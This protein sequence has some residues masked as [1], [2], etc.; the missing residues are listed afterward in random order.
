MVILLLFDFI[1]ELELVNF[2]QILK[3]NF[4]VMLKLTLAVNNS[5]NIFQTYNSYLKPFFFTQHIVLHKL[6]YEGWL[7]SKYSYRKE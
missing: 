6:K 4:L 1:F 3:S 7:I 5:E 2:N